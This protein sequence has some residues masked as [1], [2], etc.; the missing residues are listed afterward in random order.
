LICKK[1]GSHNVETQLTW[2]VACSDCG[3]TDYDFED[4]E[5]GFG[6]EEFED[7]DYLMEREQEKEYYKEDRQTYGYADEDYSA[8]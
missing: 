8:D 7:P 5:L 3:S 4:D 1:C 6:D 2:E